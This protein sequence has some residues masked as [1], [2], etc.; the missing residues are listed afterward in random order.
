MNDNLHTYYKYNNNNTNYWR[1]DCKPRI[2]KKYMVDCYT[3]L[4]PSILLLLKYVCF[5]HAIIL[6]YF[7]NTSWVIILKTCQT[8]ITLFDMIF[9]I[10]N[11]SYNN[12]GNGSLVE[13]IATA[14]K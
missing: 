1:I 11:L 13:I 4:Y 10:E 6:L 8:D 2:G 14:I 7:I 9:N 12:V 5:I 3:F